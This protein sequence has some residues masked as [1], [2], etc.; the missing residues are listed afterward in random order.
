MKPELERRDDAKIA[1]PPRR[2]QKRSL[3]LASLAS[4]SRPS[5]VMMS[6]EAR[7]SMQSP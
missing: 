7:L 3:L 2:A 5:A 4:T 6:A 1:T